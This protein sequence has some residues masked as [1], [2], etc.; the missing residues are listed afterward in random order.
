MSKKDLLRFIRK[1]LPEGVLDVR[2]EKLGGDASDRNYYRIHLTGQVGEGCKTLVIMELQAPFSGDELPFVNILHTLETA[3]LGVPRVHGVAQAQGLLLLED[4]GD[5]ILQEKIYGEKPDQVEALYR[6]ALDMIVTMQCDVKASP[7]CVAFKTA[8]TAETFVRELNF[9]RAHYIEG[10]LGKRIHPEDRRVIDR[11]F[12]WLASLLEDQERLFTHRD[13]HSRNLIYHQG[14]LKMLD[15][16]DARLGPAQYDVASLLRDSYVVL[17]DR[18][19]NTLL[20]YYVSET[21][22]RMKARIDRSGFIYVFDMASLQ[23]NLK[24]I[25]TFAHQAVER[26]NPR[27][28][29]YIAPTLAHV[30]ENLRKYDGLTPYGE[31]LARYLPFEKR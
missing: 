6:E 18:M 4:L 2:I 17:D 27:Y 1:T 29:K 28:L 30:K 14:R 9:F 20:D 21:E 5:E 3:G 26:K 23:R 16:Q 31:A 10:L 25:G 7:H 15:F 19:R 22:G 11:F 24:A 13:Y 8:F 12:L